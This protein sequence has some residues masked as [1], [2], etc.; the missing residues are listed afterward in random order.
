MAK[1]TKTK[2]KSKKTNSIQKLVDKIH[3]KV[4]KESKESIDYDD[5]PLDEEGLDETE[6]LGKKYKCLACGKIHKDTVKRDVHCYFGKKSLKNRIIVVRRFCLTCNSDNVSELIQK[7]TCKNVGLTWKEVFAKLTTKKVKDEF[8][9]E[10]KNDSFETKRK[11][12]KVALYGE[13]NV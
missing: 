13:Y 11:K 3:T 10:F 12:V 5:V 2:G 1:K 7:P 6:R 4:V 9:N 8:E